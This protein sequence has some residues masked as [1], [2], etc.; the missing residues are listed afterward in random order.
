M[1]KL[2]GHK[3]HVENLKGRKDLVVTS[4]DNKQAVIIYKVEDSVITVKGKITTISIDQTKKTGIIFD[5]V[6]ATVEIVNSSGIQL[7]A[8]GVVPNISVDKSSGI[9]IYVQTENGRKVEI[10][11]SASTEI[12]VVTPGKTENDDPKEQPIP[13]QFITLFNPDGKLV[14]KPSEHVGV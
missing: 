2:E 3:W 12:N 13:S 1:A 6:I 8:N 9:T 11:T 5:D 4:S 14:T 10:I 7:Q